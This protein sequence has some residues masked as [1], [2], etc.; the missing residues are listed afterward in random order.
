VP[1]YGA[2]AGP[3]HRRQHAGRV[4]IHGVQDAVDHDLP[5]VG[6]GPDVGERVA[7]EDG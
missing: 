4:A 1:Q 5:D 7:A 3:A 2:L 6:G